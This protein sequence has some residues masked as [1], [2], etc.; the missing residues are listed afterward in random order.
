M[1]CQLEESK[2]KGAGSNSDDIFDFDQWIIDNNLNAIKAC[3]IDHN[4]DTLDA[5]KMNNP[6]YGN[7]A[8]DSR[9]MEALKSN[10]NIFANLTQA[11][12]SLNALRMKMES[13]EEIAAPI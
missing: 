13:E 11:M 6:S 5:L 4:M 12:L 1:A 8:S 9:I 10:P 3:F 2:T 7:L